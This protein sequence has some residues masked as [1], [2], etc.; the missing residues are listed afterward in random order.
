MSLPCHSSVPGLVSTLTQETH[1][2][3]VSSLKS[4]DVSLSPLI[5]PDLEYGLTAGV[6]L[7]IDS[8]HL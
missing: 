5:P 3:V 1:V 8:K 4:K 7:N 2:W 6:N